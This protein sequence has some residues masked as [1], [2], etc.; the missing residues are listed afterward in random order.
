[1]GEAIKLNI[2]VKNGIAII[3]SDTLVITDTAS[4]LDLMATVRHTAECDRIAISKS[5]VAEDF[6]ILST[7]MAG[8]ILQKFVNYHTKLA[9][10]GDYPQYT[11]KA[12]NDFIRESNEGSHIFF[13]PDE[14][15]AIEKLSA[16][17]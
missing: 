16:A 10:V 1:L 15:T 7:G 5:A 13:V 6:F 4:A 12:L 2:E 3:H 17:V 14:Q 8:E 9:I 11:S